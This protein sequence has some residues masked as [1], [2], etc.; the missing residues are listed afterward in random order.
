MVSR[1]KVSV[2]VI[3][4]SATI[5]FAYRFIL[6]T[7]EPLFAACGAVLVLRAPASYLSTMTREQGVFTTD[8]TF[9]Y[10]GLGGSW[11]YFAF[12]E[13][14]VLRL[15]DDQS[16]WRLLCAGML[17]SDAAFC[18]SVAQAVGGWAAWVDIKAWTM[19]DHLAFWTTAPM[20]LVRVLVVLGVG[21]KTRAS[22]QK[23]Q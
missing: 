8:S 23:R 18:H 17:L 5:P 11:L 4:A 7:L 1:H 2:S 6:T 13:A 9:L 14:V 20:V 12:V 16:L 15:F 19:E 3:S 10:T 21:V 22:S